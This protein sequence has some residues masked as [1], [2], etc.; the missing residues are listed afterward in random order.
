[1]ADIVQNDD[2]FCS[3]LTA[4]RKMLGLSQ[5]QMATEF[6]VTPGAIAN[7][8]SGTRQVPGAVVRLIEIYEENLGMTNRPQDVLNKINAD[9]ASRTLRSGVTSAKLITRLASSGLKQIV[10]GNERAS[11]IKVATDHLL[12]Q[13]VVSSLGELKGLMMKLGQMMVYMNFA[14]PKNV[15][16]LLETLQDNTTPMSKDAVERVF[17]TSFGKRPV[18]MFREWEPY[19]FAAASI[20]QVHRA[21]LEDGTKVAVKVQYP[22]ITKALKSDLKNAAVIEKMSSV[23]FRYQ[24]KGAFV[25]ELRDRI[26]EECDYRL[27]A[28]KHGAFSQNILRR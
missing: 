3:R 6:N 19:P 14:L 10:A 28:D 16:V 20:G 4:L 25:A 23:M 1:V 18:Q 8:E 27:E 22:E 11:Q 7:W 24:K 15:R 17:I 5:R 13:E 9:W 12:A 2:D 26:L 21:V